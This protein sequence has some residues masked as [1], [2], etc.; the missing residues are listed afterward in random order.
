MISTQW[1]Q[2]RPQE[3][4]LHRLDI[5]AR[6]AAGLIGRSL[7]EQRNRVLLR[8]VGHRAKN[9]RAVVQGMV[10]QTAAAKHLNILA[11]DLPARLVSLARS[12]DLLGATDWQ[13]AEASELVSSQVSNLPDLGGTRITFDSPSPRITP[14]VAQVTGI[15]IH[16]LAT[17]AFK[18]GS[19]SNIETT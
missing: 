5:L 7:A 12:H 2:H 1:R 17:N 18:F 16:E 14:R 10:R 19:L 11:H 6:Q 4:E 13:G 15:A 3:Q 9:I 8:E